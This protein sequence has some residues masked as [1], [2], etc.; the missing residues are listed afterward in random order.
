MSALECQWISR[1]KVGGGPRGSKAR[2]IWLGESSDVR[3]EL[4]CGIEVGDI[5]EIWI[6]N[7]AF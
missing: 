1:A 7:N 3:G 6:G 2:V 4:I 5:R